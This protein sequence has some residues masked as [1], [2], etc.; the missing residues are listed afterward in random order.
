[1]SFSP[2]SY[3]LAALAVAASALA[4]QQ[5]AA[6]PVPVFQYAIE[7]WKPDPFEVRIVH[8]DELTEDQQKAVDLLQAAANGEDGT[9][10][11]VNVEVAQKNEAEE[12]DA[13]LPRIEVSFPKTVRSPGPFWTEEL[14]LENAKAVLDSPA[15]K[16]I[17]KK[18]LD[19]ESA[20]WV[21]MESGNRSQNREARQTVERMLP[22]MEETLT[23]SDPA[24]MGFSTEGIADTIDFSMVRFRRDDPAERMFAKMLLG[25]E[26]DLEGFGDVPIVFPIYGRGRSLYALVNKGI[27]EWTLTSAGEFLV[28]PCSCV[29]KANNPG[30][31]LLFAVDW[32]ENVE[33]LVQDIGDAPGG[34]GTFLDRQAEAERHFQDDEENAGDEQ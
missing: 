5:A 34:L 27:N 23:I 14:T 16:E 19:R 8:Q 20:V 25:T 9:V 21:L 15:R 3:L 11:N 13:P 18:L 17:A 22:R 4:A 1:M 32:E 2:K 7:N 29:I 33:R 6:C 26:R 28:A 12:G 24:D 30:V 10:A 31:D